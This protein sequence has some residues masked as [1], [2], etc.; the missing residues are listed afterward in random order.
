[1]LS[2]SKVLT[3]RLK[4]ELGK[5]LVR[6]YLWSISLYGSEIWTLRRSV[7]KDLESFEMWSW[8]KMEKITWP[9]KVTN[10]EILELI[11]EKWALLNNIL[12]RKVNWIGH[13]RRRSCPFHDAI[14]GQVTEVNGVGRETQLLDDLRNR[15]T[16]WELKEEAEDWK[17]WRWQFIS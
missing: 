11:W 6:C 15:T 4:I 3:N 9:E 2:N 12:R 7:W 10:E 13:I 8:R 5:K 14:A 17:R 16:Y 1:M